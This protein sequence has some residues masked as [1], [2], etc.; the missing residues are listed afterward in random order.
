MAI[1]SLTPLFGKYIQNQPTH[2]QLEGENKNTPKTHIRSEKR[3]LRQWK[4]MFLFS[5]V[6]F[7]FKLSA[8]MTAVCEQCS[9]CFLFW[10]FGFFLSGSRRQVV[11]FCVV[12][13][14]IQ[15]EL[16]EIFPVNKIDNSL[17]LSSHKRVPLHH[18]TPP[19]PPT[20][21]LLLVILL[22]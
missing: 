18:P 3:T 20:L 9:R 12:H 16:D 15:R 17:R 11:G 4:C 21:H 8:L 10:A 7:V 2:S 14:S 5:C 13:R 1:N 6:G 22:Y 19:P